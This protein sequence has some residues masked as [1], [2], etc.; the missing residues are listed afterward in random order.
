[1]CQNGTSTSSRAERYDHMDIRAADNH[2]FP[3]LL[4]AIDTKRTSGKGKKVYNQSVQTQPFILSAVKIEEPAFGIE[5]MSGE[6]S[7]TAAEHFLQ[8]VGSH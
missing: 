6:G 8:S 3:T 7:G 2:I 4:D 1:M 5:D